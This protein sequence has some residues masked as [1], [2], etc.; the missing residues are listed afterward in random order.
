MKSKTN[1]TA[2]AVDIRQIKT[3]NETFYT[4][5]LENII[6]MGRFPENYN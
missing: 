6:E 4:S 5:K 3:Y 1:I 2:D